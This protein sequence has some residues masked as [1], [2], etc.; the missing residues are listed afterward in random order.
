MKRHRAP[1]L[2]VMLAV[3]MIAG[4]SEVRHPLDDSET[5]PDTAVLAIEEAEATMDEIG[6]S[7][8]EGASYE[9]ETWVAQNECDTTPFSPS[10]GEVGSVL[11]RTYS[12]AELGDGEELLAEYETYWSD[13]GESVT[14]S[15]P[16]MD[17][18]A[19]A[20]VNGIGYEL[21]VLSAEVEMRAFIPCY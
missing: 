3:S 12:A 1:T 19:V 9:A 14:P 2:A 10:Q 11:I 16:N 5:R 20:R 6:D 7:V 18:S 4:C 15:S 8:M 17:P 13:K 21:A